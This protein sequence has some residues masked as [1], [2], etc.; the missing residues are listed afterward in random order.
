MVETKLLDADKYMLFY[1]IKSPNEV[2]TISW[3]TSGLFRDTPEQALADLFSLPA[4]TAEIVR[5]M[6]FRLPSYSVPDNTE[7]MFLASSGTITEC[8]D[9]KDLQG[10]NNGDTD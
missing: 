3:T 9:P 8:I 4:G 5:I 6:K 1:S 7:A 10:E 2:S